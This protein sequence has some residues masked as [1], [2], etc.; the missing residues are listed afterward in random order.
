MGASPFREVIQ[1]TREE[2]LSG[3]LVR[4]QKLSSKALQDEEMFRSTDSNGNV[5]SGFSKVP[6]IAG[7]AATFNV[8]L[9][10]GEA[11]F[12]DTGGVGVDD[13]AYKVVPWIAQVVGPFAN[14]DGVNPRIDLIV[15]T[16]APVASDNSVRNIL[17]DAV[18]RAFAPANVPK[19]LD[20]S[21]VPAIVTGVAGATPAAPA[22]PAGAV[23]LYEVWVP[24]AAPDST[25]FNFIQRLFRRAHYPLVGAFGE[26]P[27]TG[28][29][30]G[31]NLLY[32]AGFEAISQASLIG[33]ENQVVIE[34]EV[35][36]F[37]ALSNSNLNDALANPFAGAAPAGND[38]PFFIYVCGGRGLPQN[39]NAYPVIMI[40]SLTPPDLKSGRP[41]VPLRTP[42]GDTQSACYV[43]IGFKRKNTTTHQICTAI[44]D[45]VYW[46]TST[47]TD[48]T[49]ETQAG[50]AVSAPITL[51]SAPSV[52]DEAILAIRAVGGAMNLFLRLPAMP[53][54]DA[55]WQKTYTAALAVGDGTVRLPITPGAGPHYT[56]VLTASTVDMGVVG[57]RMGVRRLG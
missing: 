52:S 43:G 29:I 46:S 39:S 35:I 41:T 13:S 7:V 3:D 50:I 24:A 28:V 23:A 21:V 11:F 36:T 4:Q 8:S 33:A 26:E 12:Y 47:A 31:C 1:N 10:A 44:G 38:V 45:Y 16:P 27:V 25:T 54:S 34:G 56:L 30:R 42:R 22:V 57:Y 20:P 15:V 17:L 37:R 32:T 53:V 55:I 6:S 48:P 5:I 2:A 40:A 18:T 14:P 49:F 51:A 19:T 9:G